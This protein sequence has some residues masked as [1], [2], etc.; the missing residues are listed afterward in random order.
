L[1]S[2]APTTFS[3]VLPHGADDD[4]DTTPQSAEPED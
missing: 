1:T 2:K 4:R 3:L